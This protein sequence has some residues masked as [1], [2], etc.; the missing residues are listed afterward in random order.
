MYRA[1]GC[2]EG[3]VG[4]RGRDGGGALSPLS[5]PSPSTVPAW[6]GE[7]SGRQTRPPMTLGGDEGLFLES[8]QRMTRLKAPEDR[9]SESRA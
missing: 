9:G 4:P 6:K 2:A 3:S 7:G 1:L 8:R 5:P